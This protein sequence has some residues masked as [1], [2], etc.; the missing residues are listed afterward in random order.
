MSNKYLIPPWPGS[1]TTQPTGLP[2][3]SR[4]PD[5]SLHWHPGDQLANQK[6]NT[7]LTRELIY[8]EKLQLPG[9]ARLHVFTLTFELAVTLLVGDVAVDPTEAAGMKMKLS[10]VSSCSGCFMCFHVVRIRNILIPG[11][12]IQACISTCVDELNIIYFTPR[13]KDLMLKKVR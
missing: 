13:F 6:P 4:N 1:L 5:S 3:R 2:Y 10:N 11:N 12:M 9:F 8:L 7:Y